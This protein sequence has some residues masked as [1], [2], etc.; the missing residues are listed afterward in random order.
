MRSDTALGDLSNDHF[1]FW[2]PGFSGP[3]PGLQCRNQKQVRLCQVWV[4]KRSI[5]T[6]THP[7]AKCGTSTTHPVV[8]RNMQLVHLMGIRVEILHRHVCTGQDYRRA[9]SDG[10]TR[11]LLIRNLIYNLTTRSLALSSIIRFSS[12]I[13]AQS[14][15]CGFPSEIP[16]PVHEEGGATLNE[17]QCKPW[18]LHPSYYSTSHQHRFNLLRP[19]Q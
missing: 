3:S 16:N 12:K 18:S 14:G 4:Q 7:L 11:N 10:T 13:V 17:F 5:P 8:R 1:G 6:F 19:V 2:G 9:C 15:G